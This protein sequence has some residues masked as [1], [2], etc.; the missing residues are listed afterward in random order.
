MVDEA[1]LHASE[2]VLRDGSTARLRELTPADG[3]LV[4]QLLASLSERALATRFFSGAVDLEA[5]SDLLVQV[6]G[7]RSF[8]LLALQGDPP[9]PLA[10][11][12]CIATSP[13]RAEVAFTVVDEYQGQGLA[14]IMLAQLAEAANRLG[15]GVFEA[16]VLPEN[17]AMI[18]VFANSGFALHTDS[19]PGSVAVEFPTEITKGAIQRFLERESQAAAAA[20]AAVLEPRSVAVVG[21]SR[22][23]GTIGGE[24][25]HNLLQYGFQG[26]V[27]PVNPA[28]SVVQSVPAYRSVTAIPGPVDMAVV[29]VPAKAVND[30][31]RQ[32]VDKQVRALVVISA[33]FA[34]AGPAGQERQRELLRICGESGMRLVGPN[35]MGVLNTAE[36]VRLNATFAP[37]TPWPGTIGFLSQ[38]GALG[39]AIIES[40]RTLGLGLSSF[41]SV[42]NKAD[43]SS[44]DLLCYWENDPRTE[45]VALYLESFGNPRKFAQIAARV[46]R[47]KPIVAVRSGRGKAGAR[48]AASHTASLVAASDAT[49]DALFKHTG[50]LRTE[51]LSDLFD[52]LSMLATQPLP[53]GPRVGI[54]T[55]SGGPAILCSDALEANSLAVAELQP[56]T[57]EQLQSFL[58]PEAATGN[59]VDM[60]ASASAED[61]RRAI[62]VV[63][64]DP[65]VD[66]LVVIFTPPLVTR[67]EDVAAAIRE[68]AGALTRRLPVV[69]VFMTSEGVP[70]QLRS[71]DVQVPS[72]PFPENPARVLAAALRLRRWR[73]RPE[74]DEEGTPAPEQLRVAALLSDWLRAGPRWLRSEETDSLLQEYGI[75]VLPTRQAS[76]PQDA[77]RQAAELGFPV[78]LKGAGRAILHKSELGAVRLGLRSEEEV[79]EAA[80]EMA[81]RLRGQDVDVES[82]LVQPQLEGGVELLM[83]AV[84]DH[85]FGTVVACGAGGTAVELLH[86]T[87]VRLAP[88]SP[89]D[90]GE[91]LREL[92]TYPLLTGFRGAPPV[93][94][95][96][97]VRTLAALAALAEEHPAL[98]EVE[99][100]PV[101]VT[102]R[103]A[104]V[105]DARARIE[106]P[107][108]SLPVGA[109]RFAV[110]R[111]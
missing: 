42:G 86:D 10:H 49:V 33:G 50:V 85:Q 25:F 101:V 56:Q 60:I 82:F 40:T 28:A 39:L 45:L 34:E 52:L 102:E 93:D 111:G 44:N 24:V 98:A 74:G 6:D 79:V 22:D 19:Q 54:I 94:V 107:P 21:A 55:N 61:Y 91:M 68:A 9:R 81:T 32:C 87:S 84:R 17:A 47:R 59:P 70:Q 92:G 29:C 36:E 30:V 13:G 51:T 65:G 90:A 5:T 72:Y 2:V 104:Y 48:A 108:P 99:C 96:A 43:L 7:S 35:C 41:V 80:R 105:V 69:T 12:I 46:S 15:V 66:A 64:S 67:A 78:V 38:S 23:R 27:Y 95:D 109:K 63:S 71:G 62:E 57:R 53:E 100:N 26:P 106:A 110:E 8:G 11:A 89:T 73:E 18:E 88:V 4:R 103:G 14:S 3:Q 58:P 1:L 97:A 76:D 37:S 31:A 16:S 83:G 77:A 20:V 75:Q